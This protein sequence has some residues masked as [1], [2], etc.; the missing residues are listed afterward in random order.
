M[1]HTWRMAKTTGGIGI[2]LDIEGVD[3]VFAGLRDAQPQLKRAT[4]PVLEQAAEN[5]RARA[6][7]L[8]QRHPSGLWKGA[9]GASYRTRKKGEYWWQVLTPGTKAGRAEAISE[10]S[11]NGYSW[12]GENLV[13]GLNAYYGRSGGAGG[14]RIL[15]AARDELDAQIISELQAAVNAAAAAIQ[16]EVG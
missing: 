3:A 6:T 11:A 4:I 13:K 15:W 12:R 2:K 1:R 16:S 14:G 10:F 5:V 7:S 8:V 9:G